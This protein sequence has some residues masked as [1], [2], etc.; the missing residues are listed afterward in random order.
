MLC[1]CIALLPVRLNLAF[2]QG[3]DVSFPSTYS[4]IRG[5]Y[6]FSYILALMQVFCHLHSVSWELNL[7]LHHRPN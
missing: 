3:G 2:L 5:S 7:S 4:E 1:S 6:C